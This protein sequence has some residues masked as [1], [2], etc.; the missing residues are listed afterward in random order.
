VRYGE[1]GLERRETC[2][3][4]ARLCKSLQKCAQICTRSARAFLRPKCLCQREFGTAR[5]QARAR[6]GAFLLTVPAR[7]HLPSYE[8]LPS[9]GESQASAGQR[10][11]GQEC[12]DSWPSSGSA[13]LL[14]VEVES[15]RGH[16]KSEA[17]RGDDLR[18]SL[19][20]RSYDRSAAKWDKLNREQS[21]WRSVVGLRSLRDLGPPYGL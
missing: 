16:R 6:T 18:T 2:A 11:R 17:W 5:G 19:A 3:E 14:A 8:P 20:L 10:P 4:S 12:A 7:A 1:R 15:P 9:R 21:I 13:I